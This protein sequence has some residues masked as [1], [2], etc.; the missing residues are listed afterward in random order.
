MKIGTDFGFRPASFIDIKKPTKAI[1]RLHEQ[2]F[3]PAVLLQAVISPANLSPDGKLHRFTQDQHC[4]IHGW[5]R[6]DS[7]EI[8]EILDVD[9]EG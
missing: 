5:K 1:V 2:G 7:I 8:V 6:V 9:T 4:E 3:N